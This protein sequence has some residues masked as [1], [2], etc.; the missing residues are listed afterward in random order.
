MKINTEADVFPLKM[1]SSNSFKRFRVKLRNHKLDESQATNES[2]KLLKRI[3]CKLLTKRNIGSPIPGSLE[4]DLRTPADSFFDSKDYSRNL[5][6]DKKNAWTKLKVNLTEF[7]GITTKDQ[8]GEMCPIPKLNVNSIYR[9]NN[10]LIGIRKKH[11][12]NILDT[13]NR[14]I[15]QKYESI[16]S[17]LKTDNDTS[18]SS[19]HYLPRIIN[20]EHSF[21]RYDSM[22]KL[23]E[24]TMKIAS[25]KLGRETDKSILLNSDEY[26]GKI[27]RR[28]INDFDSR[29]KNS[30]STIAWYQSLRSSSKKDCFKNWMMPMGELWMRLLNENKN[31][32]EI[33]KM[34]KINIEKNGSA[35]N[36]INKP[37]LTRSPKLVVFFTY[38]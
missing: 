38:I 33:V 35:K 1:R 9:L 24:R 30:S 4:E 11:V 37:L 2:Y 27:E 28:I 7:D 23:W 14:L 26:R 6:I 36:L 20:Q 32:M 5:K 16:Q 18:A 22:Q 34:H 29:N 25:E 19:I 17:K 13:N 8:N 31:D 21:C 10:P 12:G 3:K 15:E